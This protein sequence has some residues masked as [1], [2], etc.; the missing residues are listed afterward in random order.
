MA[1]NPP[2]VV[3]F[4]AAGTLIH[5]AEPV[6]ATYARVARAH[7]VDVSPDELG[8]AF[9]EV[10]RRTPPP[11]SAESPHPDADERTWWSRLVRAVFEAAGSRFEDE[12]TYSRFFD[13]LYRRFEEP[14]TWLAAP[15]AALVLERV[16]RHHRCILLSNFDSRLR[17]ILADLDLLAPFERLFL[18]CEERL[19]K[20]DPRLFQRVSETLGVAP[21][22]ILHVGDDP[23]C[24]WAGADAAGFRTFRVNGEPDSLTRLLDELSLA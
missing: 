4:D 24:D 23:R 16:S 6:G 7:G 18:S 13:A 14:G 21:S 15:G 1:P 8:R 11:F 19:S 5:L 2:E 12:G 20:P 10:W 17:R 22:D 9:K 3:S